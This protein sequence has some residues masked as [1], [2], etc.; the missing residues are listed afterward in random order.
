MITIE[1]APRG[2]CIVTVRAHPQGSRDAV[3]GEIAGELKISTTS[4]RIG[5]R[6]TMSM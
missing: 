6:S 2:G 4:R 3:T 1:V 5:A